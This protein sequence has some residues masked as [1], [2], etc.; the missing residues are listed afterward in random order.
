MVTPIQTAKRINI[1]PKK[2]GNSKGFF[3]QSEPNNPVEYYYVFHSRLS[4]KEFC[5]PIYR[6]KN[7]ARCSVDFLP[8][9]DSPC[10]ILQKV[11]LP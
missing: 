8:A 6:P 10:V 5:F 2:S 1:I 3:V 9:S 11:S 7:V 4:E